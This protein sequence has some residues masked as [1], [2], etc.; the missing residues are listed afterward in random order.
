M[1]RFLKFGC[2]SVLALA[3]AAPAH[4]DLQ[5]AE[6]WGFMRG[7]MSGV[8]SSTSGSLTT[9]TE[10][11]SNGITTVNDITLVIPSSDGGETT[12]FI[13]TLS[14]APH[15]GGSVLVDLPDTMD[16]TNTTMVDMGDGSAPSQLSFVQTLFYENETL[17]VSGDPTAITLELTAPR[18]G[19]R[20]PA[21][22]ITENG[23]T[24]PDLPEVRGA[25][26]SID[27]HAIYKIN[28]DIANDTLHIDATST[29][30]S[31][32]LSLKVV[33]PP[34]PDGGPDSAVNVTV[35]GGTGAAQS[36]ATLQTPLSIGDVQ[37]ALARNLLTVTADGTVRDVVMDVVSGAT[38]VRSTIGV[39]GFNLNFDQH[40]M[41]VASNLGAIDVSQDQ[42]GPLGSAE[43]LSF[44]MLMPVVA[45]T[46]PQP[47][48]L[49]LGATGLTAAD[50]FWAMLDPNRELPRDPASLSLGL[51]GDMV[52]TGDL[53]DEDALLSGDAGIAVKSVKIDP[54]SLTAMG[55]AL[56]GNGAFTL[57]P[58]DALGALPEGSIDLTMTNIDT[59]LTALGNIGLMPPDVG[60]MVMFG[61]QGYTTQVDANTRTTT[62]GIANGTITLNGQA[63]PF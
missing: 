20:I 8:A 29:L 41:A 33:I 4:A 40:G 18:S 58:L 46:A 55:A 3:I 28:A 37:D 44:A 52:V 48:K 30:A 11:T 38:T 57:P 19:V 47:Y 43:T 34:D 45:G 27:H 6:V 32:T 39:T 1:S 14:F 56:S 36:T 60:A 49:E 54:L 12:L 23:K 26:T 35:T 50:Q 63:L 59:L 62:V 2:T 53:T 25:M 13:P 10:S 24:G 17:I 42:V 31:N 15:E 21:G 51:S 7:L 5:P 61:L 22:A 16:A 9:G